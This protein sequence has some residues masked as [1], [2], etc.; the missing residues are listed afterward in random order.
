[1]GKLKRIPVI[2]KKVAVAVMI[3]GFLLCSIIASVGYYSFNKQFR[4]QYDSSIR[5]IAD[6]ATQCL[7]P[8]DFDNYLGKFKK[9]IPADYKKIMQ[10]TEEFIER[11]LSLEEAQIDAFYAAT[12]KGGDR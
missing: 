5:S 10:Y 4:H 12:S 8:D 2:T 3:S 9:I 7:N 11:G 1:M 6:A